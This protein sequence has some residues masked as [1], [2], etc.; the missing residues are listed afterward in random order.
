MK[1][2][3][4]PILLFLIL[5]STLASTATSKST[6]EPC[7]TS[8]TCN[9]FL[10]YTLYTDL[11]VTELASLFQA[12]PVSILLS[13]SISTSY[14][15]VENHVL[16]SH[17][18]LKIPIT[19]SCVD[20]IRKSTS[21]RYKTRTSDTLDSIAGSVYGG[22]VSPEQIQVA[23]PDIESLDV[24]TSLVIPLPCA[25]FN[26]TDESLPAVYLSYVVRGVDTMGGIARRF[27]TTVA[28]LT[29]V[30]AMGAPDINP[31]DILAVPLLA[32][33]SN[34]PKYATDYGLIIPNGS[35]A[36]TA[37]HCVQCSC[38][39]GSRSMYCEPASLEVSCSSMQCRNS[40]FMLG[41]ITSQETSAGCKLTTCTYNGFANGT[42][43]TTLSRSLQPRCP[44]PPQLAP[45]I[46]PPDTVPKELM[47]A[48][49]P[50]PTPSPAPASDGVVS[51]GPS[52]VA[53][54]PRGP[55]VASSS[56]IP[57]YPANGPAGS[58]SIAS[59]LTSYHSLVVSFISFASYSSVILV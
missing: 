12:D 2:P 28:D 39:L 55:T 9:S 10:G 21:T 50:S 19:C 49:S 48:P 54:A 20:G 33:G 15:D 51:E 34:F 6:I 43:L 37:D 59:C 57:G 56:S 45:L 25:C 29:N 13:N 40:K 47:F 42:I 36:L 44:G 27:S 5:A 17:L 58:I 14:P 11:K 3:E 53:A 26:G 1:N 52:T 23:N 32:C 35:Y 30:N 8:S 22:L 38:A 7:S 16:P 18:F 46:A 24:G 31:G 41:N 4:K